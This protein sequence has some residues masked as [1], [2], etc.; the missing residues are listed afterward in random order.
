MATREGTCSFHAKE[1]NYQSLLN[2][3]IVPTEPTT[4]LYLAC[5]CVLSLEFLVPGTACDTRFSTHIE[6]VYE[7]MLKLWNGQKWTTTTLASLEAW[8]KASKI[9]S[10]QVLHKALVLFILGIG[11]GASLFSLIIFKDRDECWYDSSVICSKY[12]WYL[13]LNTC[14]RNHCIGHKYL[15]QLFFS[16]ALKST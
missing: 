7:W 14:H 10:V 2:S 1:P 4:L 9:P 8:P 5:A 16:F 6:W 12:L 3:Y 15:K 11:I 13:L